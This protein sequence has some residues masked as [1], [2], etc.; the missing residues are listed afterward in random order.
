MT[1][2]GEINADP[3]KY[4]GLAVEVVGLVD[5]QVDSGDFVLA[6]ATGEIRIDMQ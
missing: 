3:A 5:R 6:E 2:A 4:E 1:T